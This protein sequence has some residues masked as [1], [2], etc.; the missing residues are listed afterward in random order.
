MCF[1]NEVIERIFMEDFMMTT[2]VDM[3]EH[4]SLLHLCS[5]NMD[6][7]AVK[8]RVYRLVGV[9]ASYLIRRNFRFSVESNPRFASPRSVI[10]PKNSH[11]LRN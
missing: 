2:R 4:A 6:D 10:G 3:Y 1:N 8:Q 9:T 11:S 5:D 7:R